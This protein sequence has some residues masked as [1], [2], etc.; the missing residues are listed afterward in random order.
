MDLRILTL[1]NS[2]HRWRLA[3]DAQRA[4]PHGW[5]TGLLDPKADVSIGPVRFVHL[6]ADR[7]EQLVF[8]ASNN[9]FGSG[10]PMS[11]NVVDL[12]NGRARL[13]YSWNGEIL[14]KWRATNGRLSA[15]AMYWTW[16]DPHCCAL[17]PY[18]FTIAK[19]HGA[20]VETADDRPWL[21]IGVRSEPYPAIPLRVVSLAAN[22]PAA[23]R[24][25]A[26]DVIL[27]VINAPHPPRGKQPW[28]GLFDQV[29]LLRPGA[30]AVLL[31]NRNGVLIRVHV[32]VGSEKNALA[33]PGG[34]TPSIIHI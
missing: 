7:R 1:D 19:R 18:R 4:A 2:V 5:T 30:V 28:T 25:R 33:F 6:L 21:G 12:K 27:K 23:G 14:R 8:S 26:G 17:R 24:L 10:I 31:V 15:R 3:W 16:N 11:L 13:A 29:G 9:Y 34:E 32:K 20:L 22:S